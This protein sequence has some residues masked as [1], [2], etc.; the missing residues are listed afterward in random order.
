MFKC[1]CCGALF[2]EPHRYESR[3]YFWGMPCYEVFAECPECHEEDFDEY[4]DDEDEE[5]EEE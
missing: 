1:N 2:D 4:E 3:E 5:E